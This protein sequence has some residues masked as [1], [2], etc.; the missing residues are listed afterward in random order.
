[1]DSWEE[2]L[3][4]LLSAAMKLR[5]ADREGAIRLLDG[6]SAELK[7]FGSW[8]YARGTLALESKD[9]VLAVKEF[10]A[11]VQMEPEVPE[12]RANLGAALLEKVKQGDKLT[13]PRVLKLME[14][15]VQQNPKLPH[16]H[17]NLGMARLAGGDA[18]GALVCFE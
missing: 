9:V 10:E 15:A 8:H 16:V 11:A 13:L 14:E 17:T 2:Q 7:A 3:D 12:F 5:K 6:A 4:Q 1:M 18:A